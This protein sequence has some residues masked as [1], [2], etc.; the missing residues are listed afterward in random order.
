ME[1]H[2]LVCALSWE[3][4]NAAQKCT[5]YILKRYKV[6]PLWKIQVD[7]YCIQEWFRPL[8]LFK[9][10]VVFRISIKSVVGIL[11]SDVQ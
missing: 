10:S 5:A 2:S 1:E 3:M 4:R 9:I 7:V 11:F 6:C 8:K